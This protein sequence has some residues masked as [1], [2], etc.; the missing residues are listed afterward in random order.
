[1]VNLDGVFFWLLGDWFWDLK[2]LLKQQ[3]K[4]ELKWN[5]LLEFC[6]IS[7]FGHWPNVTVYSFSLE[8]SYELNKAILSLVQFNLAE[9]S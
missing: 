1:M 4:E 9:T 6:F 2:G 3:N 8:R 7:V 5:L